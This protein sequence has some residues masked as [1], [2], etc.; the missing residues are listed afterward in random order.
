MIEDYLNGILTDEEREAFER[1]CFECDVC[2]RAVRMHEETVGLIREEGGTFYD[3]PQKR[4]GGLS[5]FFDS[6][7]RW[8]LV[9]AT[10]VLIAVLLFFLIP[11]TDDPFVPLPYLEA[12]LADRTRSQTVE[13]LSPG[14][15]EKIG[16]L[17]VFRW[18]GSEEVRHLVILNH[19]GEEAGRYD[20]K[21]LY[22]QLSEKL[23]A[24][25]YYW[26]LENEEDML[27]LGKFI[28]PVR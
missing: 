12:M 14:I 3:D 10:A 2:Y 16:D 28:V 23:E 11:K 19:R 20:T 1:H 5:A 27:A 4:R 24:G 25:L 7:P 6:F 15:G 9:P 21:D 8:V 18:S 26:K 22:F 13:I 17:L